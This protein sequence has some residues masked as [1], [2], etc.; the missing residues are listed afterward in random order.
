MCAPA[1]KDWICY[2]DRDGDFN[3]VAITGNERE[4]LDVNTWIYPLEYY[5]GF[6]ESTGVQFDCWCDPICEIP[7]AGLTF[8][9]HH[10]Q[11]RSQWHLAAVHTE[12]RAGPMNDLA[13]YLAAGDGFP[14]THIDGDFMIAGAI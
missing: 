3:L 10:D 1:E 8:V 5:P 6:E 4:K 13:D 7:P 12:E 14:G 9:C 11:A 2:N